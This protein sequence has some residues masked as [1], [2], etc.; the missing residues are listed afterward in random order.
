MHLR[1]GSTSS[2]AYNLSN[3]F[4]FQASSQLSAGTSFPAL[5][6]I[7]ATAGRFWSSS[8]LTLLRFAVTLAF[9]LGWVYLRDGRLHARV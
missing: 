3:G 8:T 1:S 7:G 6:R 2:N 9:V 4:L 5:L